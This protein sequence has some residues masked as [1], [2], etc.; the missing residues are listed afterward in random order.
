MH[1]KFIG[2]PT[3]QAEVND[4]HKWQGTMTAPVCNNNNVQACSILSVS[5]AFYHIPAGQ[6]SAILNDAADVALGL[7]TSVET[8]NSILSMGASTYFVTAVTNGTRRNKS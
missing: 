3:I 8:I 6:T 1:F 2:N 7:G 5:D 4:P